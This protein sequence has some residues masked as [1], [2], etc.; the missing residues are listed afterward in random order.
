MEKIKRQLSQSGIIV[1]ALAMVILFSLLSQY[2]L[3]I[4]NILSIVQQ[5]AINL[6]IALGMSFVI[7]T[8]GIDLSVGAIVALT[9]VIMA[10]LINNYG[11]PILAGILVAFLVGLIAGAVNGFFVGVV[12]LQPFIV[13][14]AS[15]TYLRGLALVYTSGRPIYGLSDNFT[16]LFAGYIGIVPVMVI[17]ALAATVVCIFLMR[18][19]RFGEYT[20]A[21]GGNEEA[22]RLCGMNVIK[23]KIYIYMLS[24]FMSA[25]GGMMLAARLDA[26]EPASGSS[27]ELDAIAAVVLGGT[28]MSGGKVNMI[29]CVVGALILSMLANGLTLLNIQTYYQQVATG[30]VILLAVILDKRR[31]Q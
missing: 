3:T 17:W 1:V 19:T 20:L 12:G 16:K 11:I 27:Y 5:S 9:S 13:T 24:G 10:N 31:T 6:V 29:G 25:L 22:S 30:L 4:N 15:V 26:A 8:G 18:K 28:S 21:I 2:F 7:S 23:I 14:L